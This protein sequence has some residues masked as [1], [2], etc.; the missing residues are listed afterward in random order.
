MKSFTVSSIA[1]FSEGWT[2]VQ[3]TAFKNLGPPLAGAFFLSRD[4]AG[5]REGSA[6][7][8]FAFRVEGFFSIV[9][10]RA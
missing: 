10:S 9:M 5:K 7:S 6:N 2:L 8:R 1:Y 3:G 4:G